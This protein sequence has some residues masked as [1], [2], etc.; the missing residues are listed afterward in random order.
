MISR[1]EI[2]IIIL[3]SVNMI[4]MICLEYRENYANPRPTTRAPKPTTRAT[5]RR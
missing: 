3:L 2:A 4:L 5:Q 1:F